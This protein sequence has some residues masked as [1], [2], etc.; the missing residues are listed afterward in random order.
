MYYGF[1]SCQINVQKQDLSQ[2]NKLFKNI[3]LST[4]HPKIGLQLNLAHPS[5]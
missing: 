1:E 4:I 3:L 2:Q 5:C